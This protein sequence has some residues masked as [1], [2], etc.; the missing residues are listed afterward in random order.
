MK[1]LLFLFVL[2]TSM[3]FTTSLTAQELSVNQLKEK[4]ERETILRLTQ[5][6]YM[7]NG[8]KKRIGTF[9]KRISEEFDFNITPEGTKY[10]SKFQTQNR[11]GFVL[12]TAGYLGLFTAMVTAPVNPGVALTLLGGNLIIGTAST[13][14]LIKANKN[15]NRA[16]WYRNRDVLLK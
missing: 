8:E 15:L 2:L 7:K 3:I 10:F 11:N 6:R 14:L 4:Y 9:G 1:K 13:I 12:F 5:S 16:I